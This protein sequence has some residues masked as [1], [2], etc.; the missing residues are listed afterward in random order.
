MEFT[1]RSIVKLKHLSDT[2]LSLD[3]EPVSSAQGFA[4]MWRLT[5]DNWSFMKES[6]AESRLQR[7]VGC[8]VRGKD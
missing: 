5:L 8:L 6:H 7:H 2:K 3:P 4:M 1:N